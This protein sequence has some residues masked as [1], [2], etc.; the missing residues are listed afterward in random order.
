MF[1]IGEYKLILGFPGK[2]DGWTTDNNIGVTSEVDIMG[3]KPTSSSRQ[4]RNT[5][6]HGQA[7][8]DAYLE[9]IDGFTQLYN[10]V[11]EFHCLSL[12]WS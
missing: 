11:G 6:S 7:D 5:H 8:L 9:L 3:L 2:Y 10:V 1:S 12:L 4:K